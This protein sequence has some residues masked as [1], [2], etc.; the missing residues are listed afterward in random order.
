MKVQRCEQHN[1]KLKSDFGRF[2]D[3]YCFKSKNLYNYANFILRQEFTKNNHYISYNQLF[4]M[5]KDSESY[6]EIGSNTGQATLRM[7]DKAWKSFYE[8]MR[9]Y[10]KDPS[11]YLGKPKIPKYQPKDGRY[12]LCLDS[13][14][15]KLIDGY[16][17]FAWKPFKPF[18]NRYQTN[19]KDRI[20]QCRFIPK[21]DHYVM[22][23]IYEIEVID[24]LDYSERIISIDLGV[25][26]FVTM[27]NNF[28]EQPIVIKG[29]KLKS[30]N[31]Y[32]NKEKAKLQSEL[33]KINRKHWSKKLQ[34][35]TSKRCEKTKYHMHCVSKYIVDYC[36]LYEVDT[37]VVG[38]NDGWKQGAKHIQNFTY[39][40]YDLFTKMLKYKC[41]N[42]GIRFIKVNEAYTS[43]TSFLDSEEPC[44][45]NYDKKRRV[46]RGLFIS[47]ENKEINADVNGAYQI[48]KKAFPNVFSDG[49]EGV[50]LHPL[51]VKLTS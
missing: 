36:V 44:K 16:V 37:L 49:I 11:K 29:G 25:E 42:N 39:I 4:S 27:V 13:N 47:N 3:D 20:L 19:A 31:Q 28:G 40:P 34:T 14:K 9:G 17:Y 12:T 10:A 30:I 32:Y 23:I 5:V 33:A 18:N 6:K 24:C 35:L 38:H 46:Q 22:E 48:M 7:L 15:V 26:N 43:G 2:I 8:G 51:I 41:E 21:H 1:I 50:G 45:D